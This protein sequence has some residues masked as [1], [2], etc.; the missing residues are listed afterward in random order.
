MSM[1]LEATLILVNGQISVWEASVGK[2]V[3]QLSS[4]LNLLEQQEVLKKGKLGVLG[5][6]HNHV[7]CLLQVKLI[8]SME[9]AFNLI[10]KEK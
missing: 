9:R 1:E 10:N 6:H 7:T 3:A 4:I 5:Q 2:V 8:Q